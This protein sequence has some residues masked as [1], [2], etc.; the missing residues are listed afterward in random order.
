MLRS[1]KTPK[2]V[3]DTG[4]D[5]KKIVQLSLAHNGSFNFTALLNIDLGKKN[6]GKYAN[7]F[8]YNTDKGELEFSDCSLI[9]NGKASIEFTHASDYAILIDSEPLGSFEDVS[10]A[11]GALHT[12]MIYRKQ[13]CLS[14]LRRGNNYCRWNFG[15]DICKAQTKIKHNIGL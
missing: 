15:G 1:L 13:G 2:T 11:A 5:K 8:Y 14:R 6:Y 3:A 7:L 4:K 12:A 9:E 10:T